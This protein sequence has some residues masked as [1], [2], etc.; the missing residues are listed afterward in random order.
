MTCQS[1]KL[2]LCLR[3]LNIVAEIA[4]I[5][6][7]FVC[8]IVTKF[9]QKQSRIIRSFLGMILVQLVFAF[10][11]NLMRCF[12]ILVLPKIPDQISEIVGCDGCSV[13]YLSIWLISAQ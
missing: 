10:P 13:F 3:K 2:Y 7:M 6:S 5:L 11:Y 9:V 8:I 4:D 1:H 12:I